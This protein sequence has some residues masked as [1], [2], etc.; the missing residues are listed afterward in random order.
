M[1]TLPADVRDK[2]ALLLTRAEKDTVVS[3]CRAILGLL[4]E[5]GMAYDIKVHCRHVGVHMSNRDGTGVSA[6]GVQSLLSNIFTIGWEDSEL[7]ALAVEIDDLSRADSISFNEQLVKAASGA[8]GPI[9]DSLMFMSLQGSHTNQALRSVYYACSHP[10][11]LLTE[12]GVLSLSKIEAKDKGLAE[13]VKNGCSWQV[14]SSAAVRLFPALP[15]LLQTAGNAAGQIAQGE[16]EVQMLQRI[17]GVW[18][19]EA[20]VLK[21]GHQVDF[22]AVKAKVLAS[23]SGHAE[24][25]APM[26]SFMLKYCGGDTAPFLHDSV[27]FVNHHGQPTIK[28][29]APFYHA[30]SSDTKGNALE[31]LV[32][33]RHAVLKLA[34]SGS[35]H[36]AKGDVARLL[37]NADQEFGKKVRNAESLMHEYRAAVQP[38][39]ASHDPVRAHLNRMD[40]DIVRFLLGR[41][42]QRKYQSM[43]AVV[44]DFYKTVSSAVNAN[45][46]SRF[47][48]HASTTEDYID[49]QPVQCMS[50]S[51]AMV[52]YDSSSNI[53]NLSEV[54]AS[55]G[56]LVGVMVKHRSGAEGTIASVSNT[57]VAVQTEAGDSTDAPASQFLASEWTIVRPKTGPH[58]LDLARFSFSSSQEFEAQVIKSR[59]MLAINEL[60]RKHQDCEGGVEVLVKPNMV[61]A[62]RSFKT[63]SLVMVP[64]S[65]RIM[66]KIGTKSCVPTS[67]LRVETDISHIQFWLVK[68]TTMTTSSTEGI[69][70]P[71]WYLETSSDPDA[72]NLAMTLSDQ[73]GSIK[74]PVY[75]NIKAVLSGEALVG[76]EVSAQTTVSVT[77]KKKAAKTMAKSSANSGKKAK[78]S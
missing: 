29:G 75:K 58:L 7:K 69:V 15:Q 52:Q 5:H 47:E 70:V 53:S 63:G 8:L 13:A 34:Y 25:I 17:H 71:F 76:Q 73:G 65:M 68:P 59:I 27:Q 18:R 11:P 54:L 60:S 35:E 49:K 1:T 39:I 9:K 66:Y 74:I 37:S 28:L 56:Y 78:T 44:H 55:K 40:C 14:V 33:V 31:R 46:P 22:A 57:N 64:T 12:N 6:T 10:N 50:T 42:L 30:L 21:A 51:M 41:K 32:Q 2:I 45:I 19:H 36:V 62:K 61:R 72:H 16:H 26:Y 77:T 24:V 4:R 43:E 20:S 23:A 38:Y 48:V 3:S 67:G